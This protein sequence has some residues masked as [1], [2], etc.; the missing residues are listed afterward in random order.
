MKES[1]GFK[2]R[3]G[4]QRAMGSFHM[5]CGRSGNFSVVCFLLCDPDSKIVPAVAIMM[6]VK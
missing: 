5:A 2:Y 6:R 1:A 4:H 3:P